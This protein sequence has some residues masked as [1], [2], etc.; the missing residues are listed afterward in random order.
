MAR[1]DFSLIK[2]RSSWIRGLETKLITNDFPAPLGGSDMSLPGSSRQRQCPW[3]R[4][5]GEG[6]IH[7]RAA[8]RACGARGWDLVPT[9]TR[10]PPGGVRVPHQRCPAAE[11]DSQ[12]LLHLTGRAVVGGKAQPLTSGSCLTQA[13]AFPQARLRRGPPAQRDFESEGP[14]RGWPWDEPVLLRFPCGIL[15]LGQCMARGACTVPPC[16]P[17][18]T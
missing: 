15:L 3:C 1:A 18:V 8:G 10:H 6:T 14:H 7:Q 13:G 17:R 11:P 4:A 9:G 2:S 5:G 16:A 12:R